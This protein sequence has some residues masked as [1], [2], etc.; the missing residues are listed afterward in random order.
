M[1]G[2][3][4]ELREALDLLDGVPVAGREER[5]RMSRAEAKILGLANTFATMEKEGRLHVGV[6]KEEVA[7]DQA[8]NG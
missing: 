4:K 8:D 1:T 6:K 7:N 2:F 5:A 3:E